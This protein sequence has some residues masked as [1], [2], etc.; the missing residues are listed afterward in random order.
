M[1]GSGRNRRCQ[2]LNFSIIIWYQKEI[3]D[4]GIY[5][6]PGNKRL[7]QCWFNTGTPSTMLAQHQTIIGSAHLLELLTHSVRLF[8]RFISW[9]GGGGI[10]LGVDALLRIQPVGSSLLPWIQGAS[11]YGKGGA[12]IKD[13]C[14]ENIY[15][16]R[17]V[18][19]P[20]SQM[21][22]Q[23]RNNIAW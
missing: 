3:V 10:I 19:R 7:N 15:Q 4:C 6:S 18:L 9:G 21:V 8:D 22:G 2:I 23:L 5:R 20:T 13:R 14:G 12:L 1:A 16:C 11:V 17:F